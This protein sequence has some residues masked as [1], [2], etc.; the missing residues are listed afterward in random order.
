MTASPP[1]TQ[2]IIIFHANIV[3]AQGATGGMCGFLAAKPWPAHLFPFRLFQLSVTPN[4]VQYMRAIDL[5]NL[6]SIKIPIGTLPSMRPAMPFESC[7]FGC[8]FFNV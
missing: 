7:L 6:C 8:M 5:Y 1:M 2:K 3:F 4:N